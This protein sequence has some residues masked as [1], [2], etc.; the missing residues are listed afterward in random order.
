[1]VEHSDFARSEQALGDDNR[2]K[3][4]FTTQCGSATSIF[5]TNEKNLR[6]SACVA[7]DVGITFVNPKFRVHANK[8]V[9]FVA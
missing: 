1:M 7:D 2:T 5:V 9:N 6:A 8:L 3:G 4:V